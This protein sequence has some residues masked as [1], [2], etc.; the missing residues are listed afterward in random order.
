MRVE[1]DRALAAGLPAD[2]LQVLVSARRLWRQENADEPARVGQVSAELPA[3]WW[4]S[5]ELRVAVRHPQAPL[6]D[7]VFVRAMRRRFR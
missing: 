1:V 5:E 6:F 3:G 2:V 4:L 7:E